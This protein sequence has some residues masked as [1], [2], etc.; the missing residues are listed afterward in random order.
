MQLR[1]MARSLNRLFAQITTHGSL[2]YFG[3][4]G[5]II[6]SVLFSRNRSLALRAGIGLA[7]FKRAS[8]G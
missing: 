2:T 1:T 6:I 5:L 7:C 4:F 3:Y 8:V